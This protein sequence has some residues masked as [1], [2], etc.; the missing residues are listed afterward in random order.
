MSYYVFP[1]TQPRLH[2]ITCLAEVDPWVAFRDACEGGGTPPH[3]TQLGDLPELWR[4]PADAAGSL[5]LWRSDR[6]L[7]AIEPSPGP[8]SD[9]EQL[10]ADA[11]RDLGAAWEWPSDT[12]AHRAVYFSSGG[13]AILLLEPTEPREVWM[14][15]VFRCEDVPRS[16]ASEAN[17]VRMAPSCVVEVMPY[18]EEEE[19]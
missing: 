4:A 2:T 11:L 12:H 9:R 17:I 19:P 15:A 5:F 8:G 3:W 16:G 14:V 18:E 6:S 1:T 13:R 10:A 7:W